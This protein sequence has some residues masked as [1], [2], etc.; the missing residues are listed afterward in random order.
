[1]TTTYHVLDIAR[2]RSY[3]AALEAIQ[4][5]PMGRIIM[6]DGVWPYSQRVIKG[7][8]GDLDQPLSDKITCHNAAKLYRF[9]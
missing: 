2:W 3:R 4:E 8:L 6:I 5:N 9:N 7:D 1:M